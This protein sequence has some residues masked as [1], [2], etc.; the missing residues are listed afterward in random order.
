MPAAT[1]PVPDGVVG[2]SSDGID[3]SISAP[4]QTAAAATTAAQSNTPEV[5]D[6]PDVS[7]DES[8]VPDPKVQGTDQTPA[9]TQPAQVS[10]AG[11]QQKAQTGASAATEGTTASDAN[12][13]AGAQADK[14]TMSE[15][16]LAL[17]D[18]L[19]AYIAASEVSDEQKEIYRNRV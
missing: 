18:K 13:D 4:A 16:E 2:S 5:I 6:V 19:F 8:S 1:S 12:D 10:T 7:G 11:P 9:E 17:Q 15:A 14:S 3:V